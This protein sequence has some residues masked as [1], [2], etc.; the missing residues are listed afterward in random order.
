MDAGRVLFCFLFMATCAVWRGKGFA[1]HQFLDAVMTVNAVQLAVDGKGKSIGGENCQWNFIT[2]HD[3]NV[4]R[5]QMTVEAIGAGKFFH[6]VRGRESG[7][8]GENE[9]CY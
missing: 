8:D 9:R 1:M 4:V 3:A 2:V 5:V 7:R 6:R